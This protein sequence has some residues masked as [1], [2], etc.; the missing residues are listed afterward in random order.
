MEESKSSK[1]KFKLKYGNHSALSK[2]IDNEV[3]R[4]LTNDRLTEN[5]LKGLD[6][7]IQREAENRDKKSQILEDRKSQRSQ[8][9]H[10]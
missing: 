5:N 7:K 8:S 6:T 3:Q 10:S 2:F 1:N 9:A 4:F